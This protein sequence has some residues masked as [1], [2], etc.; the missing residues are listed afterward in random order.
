MN[1]R[2][3]SILVKFKHD[4]LAG[5][6]RDDVFSLLREKLANRALASYIFG[7]FAQGDPGTSSDID[8]IVICETDLPFSERPSA[9]KDLFDTKIQFDILVYT[10]AEWTK[11]QTEESV[12]FWKT[13]KS[14]LIRIF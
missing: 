13:V 6:S 9:F 11:I 8:L 14:Q 12:G 1:H 3:E 2:D 4:P 7:S 10:A 5:L